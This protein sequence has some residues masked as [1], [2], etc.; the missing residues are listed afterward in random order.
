MELK[1]GTVVTMR[2]YS[3]INVFSSIVDEIRNGEIVARL[4]KECQKAVFWQTTPGHV[5]ELTKSSHKGRTDSRLYK[6]AGTADLQG[7][8]VRRRSKLRS[9]ERFPVSLYAD[10]R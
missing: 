9:Y 3:M 6:G 10:Y 1:E 7:R 5:Y 4:P 2:H 8:R